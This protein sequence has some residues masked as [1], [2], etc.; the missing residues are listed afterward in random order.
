LEVE[1]LGCGK[2]HSGA[3]KEDAGW[4]VVAERAM[5]EC[6]RDGLRSVGRTCWV[7]WVC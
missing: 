1:D 5:G 7:R 3:V 2:A 4:G 6:V